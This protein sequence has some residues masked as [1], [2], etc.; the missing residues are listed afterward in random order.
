MKPQ[1]SSHEQE[2]LRITQADRLA[3]RCHWAQAPG[4]SS[5]AVMVTTGNPQRRCT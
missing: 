1:L 5:L 3:R 4:V 2:R